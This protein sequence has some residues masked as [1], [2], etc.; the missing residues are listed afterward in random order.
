M[1]NLLS[2]GS[3]SLAVVGLALSYFNPQKDTSRQV[4]RLSE[5]DL[6]VKFRQE[7]CD[8]DWSTCLEDKSELDDFNH[9]VSNSDGSFDGE[10]FWRCERCQL[11]EGLQPVKVN[12]S[13]IGHGNKAVV[14]RLSMSKFIE[15]LSEAE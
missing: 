14:G 1:Q 6:G 10:V 12:A 11:K 4:N 9:Y 2:I 15:K 7:N 3:V 5:G 8:H 13:I